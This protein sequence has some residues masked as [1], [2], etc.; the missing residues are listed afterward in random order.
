MDLHINAVCKTQFDISQLISCIFFKWGI[1]ELGDS[2]FGRY[3][4][5]F[6]SSHRKERVYGS[7]VVFF[8]TTVA[9]CSNLLH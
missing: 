1:G 7:R 9:F 3:H 5:I 4:A 8:R 6:K 2:M